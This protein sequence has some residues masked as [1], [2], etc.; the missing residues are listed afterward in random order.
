MPLQEISHF[1]IRCHF[2]FSIQDKFTATRQLLSLKIAVSKKKLNSSLVDRA[3][4]FCI[5]V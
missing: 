5:V 2:Q 3:I 1:E 4:I